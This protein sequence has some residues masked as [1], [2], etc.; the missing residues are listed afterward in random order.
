M[1]RWALSIYWYDQLYA[2]QERPLRI[3]LTDND[4][5]K[6]SC[7]QISTWA[8]SPRVHVSKLQCTELDLS[9]T[10][11]LPITKHGL[12]VGI[13]ILFKAFQGMLQYHKHVLLLAGRNEQEKVDSDSSGSDA[14]GKGG[15]TRKTCAVCIED[16]RWV[17]LEQSQI[18]QCPDQDTTLHYRYFL[19][20]M[21]STGAGLQY[22]KFK[23]QPCLSRTPSGHFER[24]RNKA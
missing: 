23:L 24:L 22:G 18:F 16:Y 14:G 1:G 15:G 5:Y 10:S 17:S 20:S 6:Y 4:N 7:S 12:S 3:M 11:Q 21:R 13:A 19:R 9:E 8:I 2:N